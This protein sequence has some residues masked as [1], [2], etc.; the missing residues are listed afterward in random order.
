MIHCYQKKR[1]CGWIVVLISQLEMIFLQTLL[2]IPFSDNKFIRNAIEWAIFG[3]HL[4]VSTD[5]ISRYLYWPQQIILQSQKNLG[6]K[7]FA[8]QSK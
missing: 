4:V 2:S 5:L 1:H 8:N 3:G 7:K 6:S